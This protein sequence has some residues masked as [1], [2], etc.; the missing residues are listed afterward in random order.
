MNIKGLAQRVTALENIVHQLRDTPREQYKQADIQQNDA[1]PEYHPTKIHPVV[2]SETTP[3]AQHAQEPK[4]RWYRSFPWWNLL[5]GLGVVAVIAY[6]WITYLQWQDLRHNFEIDQRAWLKISVSHPPTLETKPAV[7]RAT[8]KNI[9]KS[10]AKF[11]A[12]AVF[13]VVDV[14]SEPPFNVHHKTVSKSFHPLFP[15]EESAFQIVL[16]DSETTN[17]RGFTANEIERLT[18]GQAYI[19]IYGIIIY[20]DQFG[21]HWNRFCTWHIYWAPPGE[22]PVPALACEGWNALGD[23]MPISIPYR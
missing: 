19:A 20:N 3:A 9:G 22:A 4:R 17:S 7:V 2:A 18:R 15:T 21:P 8:I 12:D 14:S 13:E 6:A 23:G 1:N 16:W 5:E 10:A 11:I